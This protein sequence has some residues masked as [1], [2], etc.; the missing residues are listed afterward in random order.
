MCPEASLGPWQTHS[1]VTPANGWQNPMLEN[2]EL[3]A[4]KCMRVRA[5]PGSTST[6]PKSAWAPPGAHTGSI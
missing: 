1:G 2:G 5:P 3:G 6:S 4:K